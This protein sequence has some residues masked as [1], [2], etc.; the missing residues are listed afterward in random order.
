MVVAADGA[1]LRAGD[2]YVKVVGEGTTIKAGNYALR[3][4]EAGIEA[5]NDGGGTWS[6]ILT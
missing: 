5:S 2:S 3:V 1:A 6:P 4:T